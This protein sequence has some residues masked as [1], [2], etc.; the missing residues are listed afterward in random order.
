MAGKTLNPLFSN[1]SQVRLERT[2]KYSENHH[3]PYTKPLAII[4]GKENNKNISSFY[5]L[6]I[7]KFVKMSVMTSIELKNALIKRISEIDDKSF[8]E[9]IKTILDSMS[10]SKVI[11]LTPD[12]IEEIKKSEKEFKQGKY[13]ENDQLENEIEEWLNEK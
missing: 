7:C 3:K 5:Y 13:I 1:F 11:K 9:A 8:L 10:E 6:K 4:A 12:L 2:G